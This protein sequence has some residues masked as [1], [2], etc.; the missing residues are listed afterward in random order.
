MHHHASRMQPHASCNH[1]A[2]SCMNL[3]ARGCHNSCK[4]NASTCRRDD[5]LVSPAGDGREG[6]VDPT[7]AWCFAPLLVSLRRPPGQFEMPSRSV[8][9]KNN[10]Q[11]PKKKLKIVTPF[12]NIDFWHCEEV[13]GTGP[14]ARVV[15][16]G[17][18]EMPSRSV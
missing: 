9:E 3:L 14:W 11:K 12:K 10:A 2:P 4:A 7:V 5:D 18:F 8:V 17:Q 16:P 6:E 15:S 1:H 13:S